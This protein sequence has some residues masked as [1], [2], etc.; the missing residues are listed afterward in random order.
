MLY[1]LKDRKE[2]KLAIKEYNSDKDRRKKSLKN[3]DLPEINKK[4]I[5]AIDGML[6]YTKPKP[7]PFY[8][9]P[10]FFIP[11]LCLLFIGLGIALGGFDD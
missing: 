1:Y 2:Y 3:P 5:K 8:Y 4:L 11:I 7:I 6:K 10:E 9:Y